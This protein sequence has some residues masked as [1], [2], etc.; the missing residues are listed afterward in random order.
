MTRETKFLQTSFSQLKSLWSIVG[1]SVSLHSETASAWTA[2]SRISSWISRM[3]ARGESRV[4]RVPLGTTFAFNNIAYRLSVPG[5][6]IPIYQVIYAGTGNN[7]TLKL[8]SG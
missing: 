8:I 4:L 2:Q 7:Y 1:F 5:G 3:C 6:T